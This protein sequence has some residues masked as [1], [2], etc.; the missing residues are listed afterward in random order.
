MR[1]ALDA[2]G[3]KVSHNGKAI[4]EV[5]F[6]K[7]IA[8]ES[9]EV[10]GAMFGQIPDGAFVGVIHFGEPN[11]DFRGQPI[12]A[13]Y[14]TLRYALILEDGNHQGVSPGKDFVLLAPVN[15][16]KD[17]G[18]AIGNEQLLKL[19]RAAAGSA[20]P[21]PWSMVPVSDAKA[22]PKAI[23]NE[24]EHVILEVTVTTKAGPLQ[25]GLIVFGKTE[26]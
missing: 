16:D 11:M 26:G 7:Q 12:K 20:H 2:S 10:P 25:I 13:G 24:H 22:L 17:P 9:R 21:S 14:Y 8:S 19:S 1:A 3:Y 18:V 4:C 5:W 23:T 15:E 6:S